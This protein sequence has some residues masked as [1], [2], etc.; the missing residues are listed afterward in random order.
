MKIHTTSEGYWR[1]KG[2]KAFEKY[3]INHKVPIAIL[4]IGTVE[5][6]IFFKRPEKKTTK[7]SI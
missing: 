7:D 5:A 1:I 2:N 6:I 3:F 4:V